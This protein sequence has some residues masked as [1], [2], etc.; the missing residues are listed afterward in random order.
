M[1]LRQIADDV[2]EFADA[3]RSN[4]SRP[5]A[6]AMHARLQ[7]LARRIDAA[8]LAVLAEHETALTE[9][10]PA[11]ST[12]PEHVQSRVVAPPADLELPPP[13]PSLGEF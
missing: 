10:E 2:R 13:P 3:V 6:T 7:D 1:E 11:A 12:V 5:S 4:E 9:T 8:A